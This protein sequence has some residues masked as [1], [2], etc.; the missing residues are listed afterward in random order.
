ME[1]TQGSFFTVVLCEVVAPEGSS[2]IV[3][4]V[5][6]IA[7]QGEKLQI[8]L[9]VFMP[10]NLYMNETDLCQ[11]LECFEWATWKDMQTSI[12]GDEMINLKE[13]VDRLPATYGAQ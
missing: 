10:P 12:A 1:G 2:P 13:Y 8:V 3:R 4:N 7:F 9:A 5:T 11:P 6:R